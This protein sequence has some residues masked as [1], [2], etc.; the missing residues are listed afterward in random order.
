MTADVERNIATVRRFMTS[1]GTEQRAERSGLLHKDFV[2]H[3]AGGLPF[4]GGYWGATG[5]F[6]RL[7]RMN[8]ELE[9]APGPIAVDP[10]GEHEVVARFRL[11]FTSRASGASVEMGIIE[12][13][14]LR[15]GRIAELDVYY[16][17]AAA[18]TDLLT[19]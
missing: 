4:S 16:K 10:V 1:V 17:D 8:D 7:E 9:L 13:Y 11:K 18:V 14:T 3:A 15:D 6:E 19:E 5:F 2:V 12:I